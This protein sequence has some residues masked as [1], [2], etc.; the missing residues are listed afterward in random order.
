[1]ERIT[2]LVVAPLDTPKL[3]TIDHT[4]E[5]MQKLVGGDIA[6]TYPWEDLVGLVHADDGIA[7]GYP[8]NR[9][10]TDEDGEVYDIVHGTF[11]LCGLG[12][13]NFIS[14]PDDLAKKYAERFK[15]P[16]LFFRTLDDHV[17]AV[18]VGSKE[19]PVVIA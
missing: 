2:V 15:Y 4:L 16:E 14:I 5:N 10:L 11:F 9:M 1:M 18:K 13:D 7:L 12:R 17:L 6:A 8:L 3:V 19:D